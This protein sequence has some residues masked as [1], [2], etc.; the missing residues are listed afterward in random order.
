MKH[1]RRAAVLLAIAVLVTVVVG[2][3]KEEAAAQAS[4]QPV[5]EVSR[6]GIKAAMVADIGG[7]NSKVT[8]RAD[9]RARHD[10]SL[11]SGHLEASTTC[12]GKRFESCEGAFQ[13]RPTS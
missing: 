5:A 11:P 13:D 8:C 2:C 3:A 4:T 10:R 7:L 1:G 12:V 6:P 9:G